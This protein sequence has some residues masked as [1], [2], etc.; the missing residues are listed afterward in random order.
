MPKVAKVAKGPKVAEV[1]KVA[2]VAKVAKVPPV[3][4]PRHGWAMTSL[5]RTAVIPKS[6][7]D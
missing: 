6:E 4:A 3:G 1:A 2:R 5:N 7:E